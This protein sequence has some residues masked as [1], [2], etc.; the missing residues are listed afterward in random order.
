MRYMN[1]LGIWGI[2]GSWQIYR[3]LL[4]FILLWLECHEF[5]FSIY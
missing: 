2:V 4:I 3:I 5:R 1:N